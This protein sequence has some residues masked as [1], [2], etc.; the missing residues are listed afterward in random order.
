[1]SYLIRSKLFVPATRPELFA[2][3]FAS[4]A[5]ALSLYLQ[6]AV[7]ENRK[8]EARAALAETG[9]HHIQVCSFVNTRLVP[10]WADAEAVAQGFKAKPGVEYTPL[11]PE[12][13]AVAT[14]G[15]ARRPLPSHAALSF[16][17]SGLGAESIEKV[18]LP[19]S[20]ATAIPSLP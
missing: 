14:T 15:S 10:G 16:R 2:K 4:A 11:G 17:C 18:S 1:M 5:D 9:L 20:R 12:V 8:Q 3:A 7:A 13:G 19:F 6:D